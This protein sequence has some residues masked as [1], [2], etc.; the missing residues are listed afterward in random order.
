MKPTSTKKGVVNL[1]FYHKITTINKSTNGIDNHTRARV[2]LSKEED[3]DWPQT[4]APLV[5]FFSIA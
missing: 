4:L 3:T 1:N 2:L 5:V